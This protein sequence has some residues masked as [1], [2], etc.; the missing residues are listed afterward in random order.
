M[1]RPIA[2]PWKCHRSGDCCRVAGDVLMTTKERDLLLAMR[3]GQ[4]RAFRTRQDGWVLM[5]QPCAFLTVGNTCSVYEARPYNCRRYACFRPDVQAEPW[6]QGCLAE[7]LSLR[8][9]RRE[10]ARI[11]RR[12]QVWASQHGWVEQRNHAEE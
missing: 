8:P 6:D 4:A 7:R 2:L 11:Q 3:P 5:S 12:A 9:V 1:S 10:Y